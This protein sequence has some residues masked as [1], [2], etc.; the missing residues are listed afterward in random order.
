MC[1]R[2]P[3]RK[4]WRQSSNPGPTDSTFML[5]TALPASLPTFW[6]FRAST[7]KRQT[8]MAALPAEGTGES[9]KKQQPTPAGSEEAQQKTRYPLVLGIPETA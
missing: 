5:F 3:A 7:L 4:K 2:P 1:P 9:E 8:G 6:V